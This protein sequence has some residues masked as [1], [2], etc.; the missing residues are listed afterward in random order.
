MYHDIIYAWQDAVAL[1]ISEL[2]VHSLLPQHDQEY[3]RMPGPQDLHIVYCSLFGILSCRI[4]H[5]MFNKSDTPCVTIQPQISRRYT[6]VTTKRIPGNSSKVS[7][8]LRWSSCNC[9]SNVCKHLQQA[10]TIP[11]RYEDYATAGVS[12]KYVA[13]SSQDQSGITAHTRL[14]KSKTTI[15]TA[16]LLPFDGQHLNRSHHKQEV[17]ALIIQTIYY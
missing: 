11:A 12:C 10:C 9:R 13:A 8:I 1:Q 17:A 4:Q 5:A 6:L 7:P 2:Q 14:N 16:E 15:T 3:L